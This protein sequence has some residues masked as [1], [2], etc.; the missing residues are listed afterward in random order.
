MPILT[1][2]LY[3]PF[4]FT[5]FTKSQPYLQPLLYSLLS[6]LPSYILASLLIL[7]TYSTFITQ[8]EDVL[9]TNY[10]LTALL[11]TYLPICTS[12]LASFTYFIRYLLYNLLTFYHPRWGRQVP[13]GSCRILTCSLTLQFTY[14]LPPTLGQTGLLRILLDPYL[15]PYF[16]IC[17]LFT[18]HVEDDGSLEDL[19]GHNEEGGGRTDGTSGRDHRE[20]RLILVIRLNVKW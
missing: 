18:A 17:L 13:W 14:F 15:L 10:V 6:K 2:F 16:T 4:L 9:A 7:C 20:I 3:F 8:L 12:V 5:F 11:I 19:V 1:W